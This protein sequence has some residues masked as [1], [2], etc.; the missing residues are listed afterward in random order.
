L[1]P[2]HQDLNP[3]WKETFD[4]KAVLRSL[5]MKVTVKDKDMLTSEFMGTMELDVQSLGVGEQETRQWYTL[6]GKASGLQV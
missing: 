6:K 4:F 1:K 3:A 5:E 2:N